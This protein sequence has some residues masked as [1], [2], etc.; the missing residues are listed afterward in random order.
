MQVLTGLKVIKNTFCQREGGNGNRPAAA[1]TNSSF[2]PFS[3]QP[4]E[5]ALPS[6]GARRLFPRRRMRNVNTLR[7]RP[8]LIQPP[9]HPAPFSREIITINYCCNMDIKWSAG[10]HLALLNFPPSLPVHDHPSKR[11]ILCPT[12]LMHG[13]ESTAPFFFLAL[14]PPC[15]PLLLLLWRG[16]PA[17]DERE[18]VADVCLS[19]KK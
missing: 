16:I 17:E 2:P 13:E 1:T 19:R 5:T 6:C 7:R 4:V 10:L 11:T 18:A 9:P 15:L 14:H 12:C 3:Q 8:F